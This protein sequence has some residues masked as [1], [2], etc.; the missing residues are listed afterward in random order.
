MLKDAYGDV[1]M[2][3][4]FLLMLETMEYKLRTDSSPSTANILSLAKFFR[5]DVDKGVSDFV[6]KTAKF[7]IQEKQCEKELFENT[8][9]NM[10]E[11]QDWHQ[12]VSY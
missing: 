11:L 10:L 5:F 7:S 12:S 1:A 4:P 9:M 3:Y 2:K 8:C 6:M